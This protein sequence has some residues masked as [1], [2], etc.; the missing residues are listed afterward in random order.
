LD[1]LS[2]ANDEKLAEDVPIA[3]PE[4]TL[5]RCAIEGSGEKKPTSE[6]LFG[7]LETR[8]NWLKT[9]KGRTYE[10]R[11]CERYLPY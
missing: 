5:L 8:F 1:D 11:A 4:F 2:L 7:M 6:E 9:E 10:V 3:I